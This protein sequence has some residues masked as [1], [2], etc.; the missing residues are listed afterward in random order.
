M[1]DIVKNLGVDG[2]AYAN[3]AALSGTGS[4]LLVLSDSN[5]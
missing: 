5:C 3:A 2:D 1:E 4:I